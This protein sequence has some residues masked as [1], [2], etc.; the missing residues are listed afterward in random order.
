MKIA[1]RI[2]LAFLILI[3]LL[4]GA[5]VALPYFFKDKIVE[6]VRVEVNKTI[7]AELE[8]ESVSLSLL[9]SFPNFNFRVEQLSLT[10]KGEFEGVALA[11]ADQMAFTLDLM[12]VIKSDRPVAIKSVDFVKPTFRIIVTEAGKAN[13]DIM[14]PSESPEAEVD[15]AGDYSNVVVQL[16]SYSISDGHLIYDDRS[17]DMLLDMEGVDHT[18]TGNFTIDVYDLDTQTKARALTYK[19]GGITYLKRAEADLN[20]I[21][22][23]DQPASKYTLRDNNLVINSLEIN[24]DG[25]VQLME[26]DIL[27]ELAFNSPQSEFRHLL[28]L[29]PNAYIAGYED[30]EA[31]G[32][33]TLKGS[34]S[35]VYN[36]DRE[37]FPAF[38]F[39][40]SVSDGRVKYP[41]LPLGINNI[42]AQASVNSPSSDFDDLVVDVARFTMTLGQNPFSAS[43]RLSNPISDPYLQAK[44][45]GRLDLA[46]LSKAF[47]MEGIEAM[48]G[49]LTADLLIDSRLSY[50]EQEQYERVD[51]SGD[52]RLQNMNYA[53]EG[54]P[55]VAINNAQLAF[56]PQSVKLS[57]FD[58][59]LGRSDLK[60]SGQIDNILAYF[61]PEKTMSGNLQ[62]RAALFDAGEWV[63]EE[64]AT[65]AADAPAY[66]SSADTEP[67]EIFDRFDFQLDAQADRF[68]YESYTVDNAVARG[69]IKPN[70]LQVNELSGRIGQNDFRADGLITGLFDYVFEEGVL[71]GDI[72]FFSNR[73]NLNDFMEEETSAEA[74]GGS[75]GEEEAYSVIPVPDNIEM[76]IMAEIGELQYTNITL[77]ELNGHLQI[78]DQAI[79]L[80][81]VRAKGLG[82]NMAMSGSYDTQDLENPRFTFKYDLSNLDFAEAFSTFNTFEQLAPIGK[83]LNGRFNS[84]LLMDGILGP[85]LY[86]KLSSIN[87]EGFLQTVNAALQNFKP[88]QSVGNKLNVNY[89]KE[90]IAIKNTRNWFEIKD[91]TLEIKEYDAQVKDIKMKIGGTYDIADLMKLQI[92][93]QVPRKLLE[94]NA[95]GAA[96][97]TGLNF[98]QG[99][100]SKL[101]INIQQSENVNVLINL[102]GAITDPKIALK[103]LGVD[104]DGQETSIADAAKGQVK[105]EVDRRV[106]EA[107]Q[108]TEQAARKAVD[109][110]KSAAQQQAEDAAKRLADQAKKEASRRI[111]STAQKKAEEV[112]D[113]AGD[114]AADKIKENLDKYNPF[115][116]NKKNEG[117]N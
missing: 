89:L 92:R 29:V 58:A 99:E 12:S 100:A 54:M 88:L 64:S 28:S 8:F 37:A 19:Q 111:D 55:P 71:G 18:G 53:A 13:Y 25:F 113:Q 16:A 108:T 116:R 94:A 82:G 75:S 45:Q 4:V 27:I 1:K 46:E 10:G 96:A 77:R 49:L 85:D 23:I 26:E 2:L 114:K 66:G 20:A 6:A 9:R 79:I 57:Q 67:T 40:T 22:N 68:V 115:K 72:R 52:L 32:Q 87:A 97:S 74:S 41:G 60:G 34:V 81:Q 43:F 39:T 70:K 62:M 59:K 61:S 105:D 117:G 11:K 69:R 44:A 80:D 17:V 83:Y 98:L 42:Q 84:T 7:D 76:D 104:G 109:S 56:T 14:L 33:F 91:G 31:D 30:V 93:A 90:D 78:T 73:M 24:A 51:M 107:R 47:P 101:G 63:P 110:I 102:I 21:F 5:A 48:S 35:G 36:G 95:V 86:P 103:L 15:T 112:L 65:E 38:Q 3:V 106:Q 50:I